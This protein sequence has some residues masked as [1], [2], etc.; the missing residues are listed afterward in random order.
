MILFIISTPASDTFSSSPSPIVAALAAELV[1]VGE[2]YDTE[3]EVTTYELTEESDGL[4][5]IARWLAA[6]ELEVLDQL[7]CSVYPA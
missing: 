6:S 4:Y 3:T 5:G 7:G 2:S 1:P